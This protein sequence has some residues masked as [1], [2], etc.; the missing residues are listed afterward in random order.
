MNFPILT[1]LGLLPLV[2]SLLLL[3]VRGNAA[4]TV[5]LVVSLVT[6]VL[7]G[8]VAY[9]AATGTTLVEQVRWIP[10]FGAWWSLGPIDGLS[11]TMVLLT[12]VLTPVVLLAAWRDAEFGWGGASGNRWGARG[13]FGL[14]LALE[15]LSLLVFMATDVLLFYLL[16]EATLIPMY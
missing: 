15:G 10:A 3:A 5:G 12:V 14:V 6:L 13:F 4:R 7:G 2:G 1:C 11:L 16:F 8:Y 9:A